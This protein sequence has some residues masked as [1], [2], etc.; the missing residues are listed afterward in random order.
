MERVHGEKIIRRKQI[1]KVYADFH[2]YRQS[3]EEDFYSMCGYCGKDKNI[4][5][6]PFE[7]DHFV[8]KVKDE[9]RINDYSNLVFSC[10]KCNR[11]KWNKWPTEDKKINH[12]DKVGFVDP[13]SEEYDEHVKRDKDGRLYGATK[14]GEY[15]CRE[16]NF[17]IRPMSMLW[18]VMKLYR[19]KQ[20]LRQKIE[21]H[22]AL[23]E[24]AKIYIEIDIEIDN[25]LKEIVEER[26]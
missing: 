1:K 4:V 21:K 10:K 8:P 2:R 19:Q 17:N 23:E 12:D 14:V 18:K 24:F 6:G 7:I 16:L 3:L 25:I 13:A 26:G 15:M 9:S 5:N 20:E 22:N 11:A